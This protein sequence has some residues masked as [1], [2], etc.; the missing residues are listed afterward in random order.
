[1]TIH[2]LSDFI[3]P[4]D[5]SCQNPSTHAPVYWYEGYHPRSGERLALPRTALVEA[6]ARGLMSQLAEH[7]QAGD[8]Y[9]SEGKMYGVLLVETPLGELR[10]LKAFSGLL[11]GCGVV[12]G[13]VPPIPGQ[14][15]IA[16]EEAHTLA[17]L[18]AMK[19]ELLTLQQLPERQQYVSLSQLFVDQWN[20]LTRCH[21]ERKHER[22]IQ[23]Q[24]LIST[25]SGDALTTA[26]KSLE[27]QSQ[28]DGIGRRQFKRKR[29]AVLQP[30]KHVLEAAD[31]RVRELKHQRKLLSRQLQQQM[32]AAYRVTNFLG[33][34]LSLQQ[35]M[36]NGVMPTGT[37]EC[38]APKLLHYAATHHLKPL[39]MA[40]FW[41]GAASANQ[42]KVQGEF[43]GA[44]AERCQPLMGFLLAGLSSGTSDDRGQ[45]P[46]GVALPMTISESCLDEGESSATQG[47]SAALH[48][49]YEDEWL[50]AVDKPP[51]LLSVPGRYRDRQDS[52]LSRLQQIRS[53]EL[54]LT[55]VHRLDQDTSGILLLS[56]DLQTHRHL[57]QQF[58]QRQVY[59]VYEAVLAGLVAANSGTIDLPLWGDPTH[60]PYQ[61]VDWSR[62]KRS[63]TQF[64]T[65]ARD[66][67]HTRMVF[68]P[69]SGRTHQLR[70]H[71][72]DPQGLGVPILG[73]RLYGCSAGDDRLHLHAREL[74]LI[75][76][77]DGRS[78]H[79]ECQ[80]PF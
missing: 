23:R 47:F 19:Q 24:H 55:A 32:N 9:A 43:Y 7:N 76:P 60:R 37:G 44:C 29:D 18:N 14:Q 63:M 10:V 22:Q 65:I 16:L 17:Q 12:D 15:L 30:L 49:L 25:L 72:A 62:G 21:R 33:E 64:Q 40:E 4:C 50:I 8:G 2:L 67:H 80:T 38:C 39:A 75:H 5:A 51:G 70:V 11:K 57:V 36:P 69:T 35:L 46:E 45:K 1:M 31:S 79:F 41:W 34:S 74:R 3:Q 6:I 61:T 42:D 71:A 58:Q 78:L 27:S 13:W 52:V 66:T 77:H 26:L 54:T 28:H 59:K 56:R 48:I 20:E 68:V 73:D 53:D